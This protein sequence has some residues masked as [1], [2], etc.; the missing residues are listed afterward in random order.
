MSLDM[1][2]AKHET[3]D[4]RFKQT[5]LYGAGAASVFGLVGA[6]AH[7]LLGLLPEVAAM[8]FAA[9]TILPILGLLGIG[10]AGIGALYMSA[11]MLVDAN[12]ID[13]EM[14]A[15]KIASVSR[16]RGISHNVALE[17]QP[18]SQFPSEEKPQWRER[19]ESHTADK[20]WVERASAPASEHGMVLGN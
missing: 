12:A 5:V 17:P 20:N 13:Q 7:W 10:A 14:Q 18:P 16:E 8:S 4:L 9:P 1:E 19:V 11:K 15:E 6:G 2:T 3:H